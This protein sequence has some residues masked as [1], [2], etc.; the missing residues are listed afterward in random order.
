MYKS[1]LLDLIKGLSD[2]GE[3]LLETADGAISDFMIEPITISC[4]DP[5]VV[6]FVITVKPTD[7]DE[8]VVAKH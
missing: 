4:D 1:E 2:E 6:G 8:E 7:E 5:T 3:I